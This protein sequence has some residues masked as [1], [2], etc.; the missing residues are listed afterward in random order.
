M[1]YRRRLSMIIAL[2]TYLVLNS[3]IAGYQFLK[4]SY[5]FYDS[6]ALLLTAVSLLL[7]YHV[8]AFLFNQYKQVWTYTGLGELI[9]LLKGITLSAAVTGIIQY[10]VYHTMFFRLLT[11][12][13]VLQLLSIGGT[14]ILSRVLNESI[15]KKQRA[16]RP[17]R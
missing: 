11:A 10:A 3:V 15:R 9:V 16:P 14:R 12:C 8:C 6:G 2:D 17:A 7:S 4:D 1:S 5:Q 13:W